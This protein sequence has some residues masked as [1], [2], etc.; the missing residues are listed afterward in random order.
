MSILNLFEEELERELRKNGLSINDVK[1]YEIRENLVLYLK[2]GSTLIIRDPYLVRLANARTR[3]EVIAGYIPRNSLLARL[4]VLENILV[5]KVEW[6]DFI[7][8]YS[9][10][11]NQEIVEKIIE[12]EKKNSEYLPRL[13]EDLVYLL[14]YLLSRKGPYYPEG[15]EEILKRRTSQELAEFYAKFSAAEKIAPDDLGL[16]LNVE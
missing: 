8:K 16:L 1:N 15:A 11:T 6:E 14:L 3:E 7:K 2:T 4:F 12:I 13:K 9:S 5:G 10:L